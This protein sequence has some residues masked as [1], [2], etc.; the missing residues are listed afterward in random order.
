MFLPLQGNV[1]VSVA[2]AAAAAAAARAAA[3]AA[4]VAAALL[5]RLLPLV[6]DRIKGQPQ[7]QVHHLRSGEGS[8]GAS[9]GGFDGGR[10]I[11][12]AV[13]GTPTIGLSNAGLKRVGSPEGASHLADS[14][15]GESSACGSMHVLGAGLHRT[16]RPL[17]ALLDMPQGSAT[18]ACS[19]VQPPCRTSWFNNAPRPKPGT[20]VHAPG[21]CLDTLEI[22]VLF[23]PDEHLHPAAT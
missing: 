2:V 9:T 23:E 15:L 5:L 6:S 8:R 22:S 21:W 16:P 10:D 14:G 7:C 20:R 3:A 4:A 18:R 11:R 1:V 19:R 12:L 17:R 13:R